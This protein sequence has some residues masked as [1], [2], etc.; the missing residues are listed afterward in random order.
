MSVAK[1][2]QPLTDR[3]AFNY[4]ATLTFVREMAFHWR[5]G[6][7]HQNLPAPTFVQWLDRV[8]VLNSVRQRT[9]GAVKTEDE[10]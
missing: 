3:E 4:I 9:D 1:L 8:I 10:V 2:S 6:T 5:S 7:P